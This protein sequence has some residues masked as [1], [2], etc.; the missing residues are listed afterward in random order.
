MNKVKRSEAFILHS[1]L[2]FLFK[3]WRLFSFLLH[4]IKFFESLLSK[5]LYTWVLGYKDQRTGASLM[6]QWNQHEKREMHTSWET[7]RMDV[8]GGETKNV[9]VYRMNESTKHLWNFYTLQ[10][11][12]IPS[13]FIFQLL[14]CRIFRSENASWQAVWKC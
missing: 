4:C 5:S 8:F 9:W 1:K 7:Q 11:V 14:H 2:M 6:Q 13:L 3:Y 12:F 10:G